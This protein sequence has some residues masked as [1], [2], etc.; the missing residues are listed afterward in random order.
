M[1]VRHVAAAS[2]VSSTP[3]S[4]VNLDLI[5]APTVNST[6]SVEMDYEST[7]YR[8][9]SWSLDWVSYSSNRAGTACR[10]DWYS[11]S[12]SRTCNFYLVGSGRL[13]NL[14]D[15]VSLETVRRLA[16]D[17]RNHGIPK[18]GECGSLALRHH[19]LCYWSWQC[20]A[21]GQVQVFRTSE[22]DRCEL[23]IECLTVDTAREI[24][25]VKPRGE[26]WGG[27]AISDPL[28]KSKRSGFVLSLLRLKNRLLGQW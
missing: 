5:N 4:T 12:S 10:G 7:S 1:T 21:C 28:P 8:L 2:S 26:V 6:Y 17:V 22:C 18:C 19:Y 11:G 13:K 16:L 20:S 14:R 25:F 27:S 3:L 23:R 9:L 24:A 15:P